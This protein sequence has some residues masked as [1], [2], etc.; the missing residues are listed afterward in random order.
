MTL[1]ILRLGTVKDVSRFQQ[2]LLAL[3]LK[4]DFHK[5]RPYTGHMLQHTCPWRIDIVASFERNV[6]MLR[7]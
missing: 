1:P 2:H 4:Q 3:G 5:R 7:W 6:T